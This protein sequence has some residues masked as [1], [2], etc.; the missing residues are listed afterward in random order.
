M[1]TISYVLKVEGP[2]PV[3]GSFGIPAL[4]GLLNFLTTVCSTSFSFYPPPPAIVHRFLQSGKSIKVDVCPYLRDYYRT[5]NMDVLF[6]PTLGGE[7]PFTGQ[8]TSGQ[9]SGP[10]GVLSTENATLQLDY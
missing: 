4:E 1:T 10:P 7:V 6:S 5:Y 8:I 2:E 3:L 9:T